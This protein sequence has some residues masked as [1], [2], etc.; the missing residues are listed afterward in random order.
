M[1]SLNDIFHVDIRFFNVLFYGMKWQ[2]Y[3]HHEIINSA[4]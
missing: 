2:L 3:S 4:K 1:C